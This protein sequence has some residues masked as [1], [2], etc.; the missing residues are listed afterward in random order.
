M[1]T[2]AR[3]KKI[4]G[5]QEKG[6]SIGD[7]DETELTLAESGHA[8]TQD[9]INLVNILEELR[10]FRKENNEKLAEIKEDLNN[11]V[12]RIQ[13]AEDRIMEAEE[14]IQVSEEVLAELLK[15]QN[16]LDAKLTDQEGRSRRENIRIYGVPEN[17]ESGSSTISFVEELLKNGLGLD[18]A[19]DLHIQRAHRALAPKPTDPTKP[20]SIVAKFLS[21]KTKEEI[22]GQVWK[23]RGI[24]WN[25]ARITVDHD[26]PPDVLKKRK[27]YTQAKK[28][29]K[30]RGIRFQTPYPAKLRVFFEGETV[31]YSS[32]EE[33]TKDFKDRG[34]QVDVVKPQKT[35][36]ERLQQRTWT[37][38]RGRSNPAEHNSTPNYVERLK[39]FRRK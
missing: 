25:N 31:L 6:D 28:A 3:Q 24:K 27:D 7:T 37:T 1:E 29:L 36:L 34:F 20:R 26:Y 17:S 16:Q 15:H 22:I 32:A 18:T 38:K 9:A 8:N 21:Y 39:S 2:R 4:P 5:R 30:D 23:K 14:R 10:D 11:T 19:T 13:E 35:L 33:A 12:K